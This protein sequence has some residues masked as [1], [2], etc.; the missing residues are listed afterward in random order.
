MLEESEYGEIV[1]EDKSELRKNRKMM[2]NVGSKTIKTP[3]KQNDANSNDTDSNDTH[4]RHYLANSF[5][6]TQ[7]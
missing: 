2:A 4:Y 5:C 3:E 1:P 6:P 7:S